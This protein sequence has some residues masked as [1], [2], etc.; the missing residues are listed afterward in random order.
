MRAIFVVHALVWLVE[1][2]AT[3]C[4]AGSPCSKT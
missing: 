1:L 3:A 4:A 2:A